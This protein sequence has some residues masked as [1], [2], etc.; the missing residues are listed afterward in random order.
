MGIVTRGGSS[1]PA[2]IL[3]SNM[4]KIHDNFLDLEDL[5][6]FYS[7]CLKSPY[8]YGERDAPNL[9]P[10]G[11]VTPLDSDNFWY[12][13]FEERS[14][15]V[16]G[17]EQKIYRMY[18]NLFLP[19]ELPNFHRD[20]PPGEHTL[21]FYPNPYKD[22]NLG[23]ETKF[24]IDNEIRSIPPVTNRS[25]LFDATLMHSAS[26]FRENPRFTLAIKFRD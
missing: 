25:I 13:V 16:F 22:L 20:G 24:V 5:K 9:A 12:K 7:F 2:P 10:T 15:E 18:I 14:R 6:S 19:R 4:I 17:I 26:S 8:Y 1:P 11:L 3:K 21:L 23:G